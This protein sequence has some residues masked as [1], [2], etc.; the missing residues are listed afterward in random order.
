M[1]NAR[2]VKPFLRICALA[3]LLG[4]GLFSAWACSRAEAAVTSFSPTGTVTNNVAF[5]IA[6]DSAIA[7]KKD[8][9]TVL[10][11]SEFPF[12]VTPAIQAEGK[13]LDQRTFSASLLAPLEMATAYSATLREGLKTQSGRSVKAGAKFT[14]QT[15]GLALL[16]VDAAHMNGEANIRLDFNMPVSPSR[17]RGFFSVAE[18][19][20]AGYRQF[21]VVSDVPSK[22]MHVNVSIGEITQTRRLNVRLAA[23]LTGETSMAGTGTLGLEKD[24][25]RT[26]ELKPVLWLDSINAYEN[27]IYVYANMPIDTDKAADFIKMEPE[28]RFSIESYG[29]SRFYIRG[30]FKPRGRYVLTFKKGLPVSHGRAVLE[31]DVTQ[32]VIMPDL[33]PSINTPAAGSVLSPLGGGRIPVELVNVGK[34]KLDLWRLY[35][36]NIPYAV[37]GD[38]TWFDRSLARRV[39][40]RELELS[41]PL[42]EKVRRAISVSDL[43]SDDRGIF[44]LTLNDLEH[45]YWYEQSQIVNLSDI[46][47]TV[48]LWEDGIL[49]WANTLSDLRPIDAAT[50]RVYNSANQLLAEGG[51]G[52]DGLWQIQRDKPWD[53]DEPPFLATVSKGREV[54]FVRLTRG[55]LSQEPFDSSGQPWPRSGYTAAVFSA[56]DIYRTGEQAVFKGVVRNHDLS[57]PE[58]FPVLFIARDPLG[59]AARRGTALPSGEG[60]ALFELDIPDNALTGAWNVSLCVPGNEDRPLASMNFNVEDFAPPRIEV[61]LDAEPPIP[62]DGAESAR[63]ALGIS[64]RYL[65]GADGAGLNWEAEWRARKGRFTPKLEK[66]AAYSFGDPAQTFSPGSD[67]FETGALDSSGKARTSFAVPDEWRESF[68]PLIDVTLLGRVMEEGGR[69]VS[70]SLTFPYYPSPWLIGIAGGG[71]TAVGNEA[72]F[73]VAVITPDEKPA[74]TAEVEEGGSLTAALYRVQWNYNLVQVDGYTR[75]QSTEEHVKIEEKEISLADGVGEVSFTPSRWGSYI[76][77]VSDAQDM[78]RAAFRFYAED[79]YYTGGE[80]GSQLLDRVEIET[81]KEIYSVGDVAKLTLRAPFEGLLLFNVEAMS[82]ISR[83]VMKVNKAAT[84]VEVPITEEMIPNA[85]CAV[86]LIRPVAEGEAWGTH[87]AIGLKRLKVD[88]EKHRL[89]VGLNASAKHEPASKLS[90][91]ISLR[92]TRDAP[93]S[94]EI[95]LALVDDAVLGLTRFETPD[96]L[97]FFLAPRRLNSDGYDIYNQLMQIEPR[98]TEPLHPAGGDAI[99]AFALDSKAQRFKILS[100][101]EGM[102][103]AD[104]TGVVKA[105]LDVPEFSGRGRLFAVAASG[106]RFGTAVQT[107]QIARDIVAEAD[108][109]RF[110]APGDVFAAPVTVFNSSE[111]SK[112]ITVVLSAEGE[113]S[114]ESPTTLSASIPAKGSH[115]WTAAFKALDPGTAVYAVKTAWRENGEERSY[116]QRIEMPVRSPFPVITLSGSGLFQSGDVK[117]DLQ[118]F[119]TLA[120]PLRGS[121]ILA[122]TPFVDL[123]RAVNFLANY[124]HG[125]LEQT[126]SSAWPFLVLPDALAEIDPLLVRSDAVRRKTDYALRRLQAM[127][128]YDG[129]FAKWPGGRTPYSWG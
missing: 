24:V 127:Q 71:E 95:A 94:G 27:Y 30:D 102:L 17:L 1:K 64:A 63:V 57:T 16:S 32:T 70:S 11:V 14:F 75:W 111:E 126:L 97:N 47:M 74:D 103:S 49:V 39:A 122:D 21:Y 43:T 77:R 6:F 52:P 120:G 117:I 86:W 20:Y 98:G 60:G 37:R 76:L 36:N 118:P 3:L 84:V 5:K 10:S 54:A 29:G 92:D 113:L 7:A 8:V 25:I 107:V 85:W 116:E 12:V 41:L 99:S 62:G 38:Y 19:D 13:W 33:S 72:R 58:A 83:D 128:L 4:P 81:D 129:S 121:L 90:V 123:T 114:V 89:K 61:E 18:N 108:L 23:G 93:L 28:T 26:V 105:E 101:F 56:R 42:N 73:R 9:G 46:G 82:L 115:R 59:R 51:T 91:E 112:D 50:V 79:P 110:A 124:P 96:L 80:D 125:C 15:S 69:W 53:T 88:T 87:R 31:E 68:V 119:Q 34:L 35:E 67:L 109:P 55:L 40:S 104:E 78:A 106:A 22:T 48:R 45:G 100:L 65:F 44:L 66:W 2:V